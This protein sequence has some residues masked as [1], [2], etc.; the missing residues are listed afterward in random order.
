MSHFALDSETILTCH[1]VQ[2]IKSVQKEAVLSY[3]DR[4]NSSGQVRPGAA[5]APPDIAPPPPPG[6]ASPSRHALSHAPA[7]ASKSTSIPTARASSVP[8]SRAR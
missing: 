4:V 1:C 7:P 8:N 2:D 3:L 5:G 6:T